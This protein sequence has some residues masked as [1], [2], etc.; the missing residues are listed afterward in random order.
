ME[1]M[2]WIPLI[3]ALASAIA[4]ALAWAAKLQWG[5]EFAAAKDE[6][7]KAKDAQIEVLNRELDSLRELTPMKV[8]EYFVSV[9]EQLEEYND[10]LQSQL[11]E[12]HEELA[13][14]DTQI[15]KLRTEGARK[16]GEIEKLEAERHRI[17]EAAASLEKHLNSMRERYESGDVTV[18]QMPKLDPQIFDSIALASQHLAEELAKEMSN[19]FS[20]L[21]K[22]IPG[23]YLL[24]L[25][26]ADLYWNTF[27]P[28]ESS[29]QVQPPEP[30]QDTDDAEETAENNKNG[31]P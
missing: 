29:G 27:K 28:H 6:I 10:L 15:A 22:L 2:E 21:T 11:D 4:A 14:K 18:W 5:R 23:N 31:A 8:R 3:T 7:I 20:D 13:K 30:T 12:A 25:T 9:R 1:T 16:A 17:A 19:H 26:G 24:A